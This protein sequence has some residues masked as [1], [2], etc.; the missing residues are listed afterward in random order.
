MRVEV[1]GAGCAKCR[2][3]VKNVERAIEALGIEA[4]VA[5]VEDLE[6]MADRGVSLTPA[7]A[8]DGEL[9]TSGR[10]AGVEELV[11]LLGSRT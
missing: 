2:R 9:V 5:K 6:E 7:V 8:V 10:V 4:E 3:Q 1:L 11:G